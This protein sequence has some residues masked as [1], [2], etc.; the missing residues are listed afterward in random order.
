MRYRPLEAADVPWAVELLRSEGWSFDAGELRRLLALGGGRVAESAGAPLG[1]LTHTV[2]GDAAWIGNVV[3]APE[4]RGRGLGEALVADAV[5]ALEAA[6]V[7]TVG[8]YS[9]PKAV[10]LYARLG[11]DR[12][13]DVA[14]WSREDAAAPAFPA[15]IAP[16]SDVREALALDRA[17]F[18]ADRGRMLA[19]LRADHPGTT[20]A[21]RGRDGR[22]EG[23][24][25]LKRSPSGGEV[26]P[27]VVSGEG[28]E[29]V[30]SRLLDACLARAEGPVETGFDLAHP[31]A[32]KLLEARGFG[33][34]F[35]ATYMIR[36]RGLAP[37]APDGVVLFGAMEKG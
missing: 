2:H 36:G 8:L 9:V 14:S 20:F 27:L 21:A 3:V 19:A 37:P 12:L 23:Y 16:L 22:L 34:G 25:I 24:A 1:L 13:R 35:T 32:R 11:F 30:A 31:Y 4:A 17:A 15:G 18:G 5:R 10:A 6:G 29:G 33:P 26:G 28:G 7:A